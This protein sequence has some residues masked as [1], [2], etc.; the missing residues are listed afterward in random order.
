[1]GKA[2]SKIWKSIRLSA[3]FIGIVSMSHLSYGSA[4]DVN[5]AKAYYDVLTSIITTQGIYKEGGEVKGNGLVYANFQD[6]EGDGVPELYI[7]RAKNDNNGAEEYGEST[8]GYVESIWGYKLGKAYPISSEYNNIRNWRDGR[9]IYL[10]HIQGKDYLV[11]RSGWNHGNGDLPYSNVM[12]DDIEVYIIE[13]GKLVKIEEVKGL[14]ESTADMPVMERK[15]FK[16]IKNQ[17]N[18][19]ITENTYNSLIKK[20]TAG[21]LIC[22]GGAGAP[23]FDI[24][25]SNN[26]E[27]FIKFYRELDNQANKLEVAVK[28]VYSTK[29]NQ[30]KEQLG[31]FLS[32]FPNAL[33]SFDIAKYNDHELIKVAHINQFEGLIDLSSSRRYEGTWINGWY[34]E[35]NNIT[36]INQYIYDLFGIK[37]DIN[38]TAGKDLYTYYKAKDNY[39]FPS[40]EK[41]SSLQKYG[42]HIMNMYQ[43]GSQTYCIAFDLYTIDT[44]WLEN[45][46]GNDWMKPYSSWSSEEKQYGE[47]RGTGYAVVKQVSN[48]G[49]SGWNLLEYQKNGG[50]LSNK[51]IGVFQKKYK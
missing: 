4:I 16:Q 14:W 46:G 7:M 51:Q 11:H 47:W 32:N 12:T 40:L 45:W 10:T 18:T 21:K 48:N 26:N 28:D 44:T 8:G 5:V 41:G 6:F 30:E 2:L 20:Y 15:S 38:R 3:V 25:T 17:K 49:K 37:P 23:E 35:A 36:S 33:T 34:Y 19:S 1:M 43:I 9:N 24:D 27:Q 22:Y 39:Y 29:S 13:K 31:R 50:M 42:T